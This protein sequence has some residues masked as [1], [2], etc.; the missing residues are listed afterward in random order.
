MTPTFQP[1][2]LLVAAI[3]AAAFAV[4]IFYAVRSR[5][6]RLE[7]RFWE[8]LAGEGT[9]FDGGIFSNV[10]LE[11]PFSPLGFTL[12]TALH[13]VAIV[14]TP[15]LSFVFYDRLSFDPRKFDV[16]L[17]EF[18]LPERLFYSPPPEAAPKSTRARPRKPA[19]T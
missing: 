10:L 13:L 11:R 17:V 12:S 18:R 7:T 9:S 2:E 8:A 3:S 14:G 15:L 4:V 6:T 1:N 5:R 19:A 16:R